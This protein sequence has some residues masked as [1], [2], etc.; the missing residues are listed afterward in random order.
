M[1]G[2][3]SLQAVAGLLAGGEIVGW[4]QGRMELGPRALGN[5]SILADPRRADIRS[6]IHREVEYGESYPPP[7]ASV[8]AEA[9]SESFEPA[10]GGQPGLVATP[11]RAPR[12]RGKVASG[13]VLEF[14]EGT[15]A[16]PAVTSVDGS[17]YPQVVRREENPVLHG[18]L[19]AFR[20]RTGCTVLLQ[21]PL[22]LPGEPL[23]C[24]PLEAWRSSM[25]T[26]VDALAIGPFLLGKRGQPALLDDPDRSRRFAEGA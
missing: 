17:A 7:T 1:G 10:I 6:R 20:A 9:S 2:E 11:V 23:V 5:R 18:L 12:S 3:E 15:T 24:T 4:F 22:R 14:G 16:P 8:L 13:R 25:R 21:A 26:G 19:Q